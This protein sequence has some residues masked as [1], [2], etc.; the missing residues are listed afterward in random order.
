ML[1]WHEESRAD[2]LTRLS[3]I[4]A[5]FAAQLL[6]KG[7]SQPQGLRT[8]ENSEGAK[9]TVQLSESVS[10]AHFFRMWCFWEEGIAGD[11]AMASME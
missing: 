10:H 3:L 4:R 1:E 2:M 11:E 9:C 6:R 5:S 8:F 7:R